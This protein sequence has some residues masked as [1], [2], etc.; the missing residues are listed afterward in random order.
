MDTTRSGRPGHHD[1]AIVKT[2]PAVPAGA[3]PAGM[4]PP[5]SLE[6]TSGSSFG[7]SFGTA[8]TGVGHSGW[9]P[10]PPEWLDRPVDP[11]ERLLRRRLVTLSGEITTDSANELMAKLLWLDSEDPGTPIE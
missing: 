11:M 8:P 2:S 9:G 4:P 7:P 5:P 1:A 6:S 3:V 10:V